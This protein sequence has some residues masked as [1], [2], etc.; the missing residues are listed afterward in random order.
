VFAQHQWPGKNVRLRLPAY[1]IDNLIDSYPEEPAPTQPAK[2]PAKATQAVAE[3]PAEPEPIPAGRYT[4]PVH[5]AVQRER[6]K[7]VAMF[8]EGSK[9]VTDGG[10]IGQSRV[11]RG[12]GTVVRGEALSE[13]T[14]QMIRA[15]PGYGDEG[16][17]ATREQGNAGWRNAQV[18]QAEASRSA[19]RSATAP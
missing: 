9:I 15:M 5:P 16:W 12:D 18:A 19:A 14:Q 11:F 3:P 8:G 13:D 17:G 1:G 4:P 7:F 2:A 6:E 10:D